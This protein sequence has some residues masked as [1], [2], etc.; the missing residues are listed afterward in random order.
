MTDNFDENLQK[1]I[2]SVTI[3]AKSNG[4]GVSQKTIYQTKF[5]TII[6]YAFHIPDQNTGETHHFVLEFKIWKRKNTREEWA[7]E[8]TEQN[9][10]S[11]D[12]YSLKIDKPEAVENLIKFL[13]LEF[14][15]IGKKMCGT[16]TI[17]DNPNEIDFSF[18]STLSNE[19]ISDLSNLVNIK[20][21]KN[22][23]DEW[24]ENKQNSNESYWQNLLK[25]N[26]LILSQIFACPFIFIKDQFFCGGKTGSN[27]GGI[28]TDFIYQNNLTQNTAFIEIKTPQ[29][30]LVNKSL[31]LGKNDD[32]NNAI[33]SISS[34]LTGGVNEVLNQKNIFI[35][36]KDSIEE[37]E[38]QHLNFKCVFLGGMIS[39]LTKGQIKSFELYRSSLRDVE[40]I[41]Y[42]ELF[43]RIELILNIFEK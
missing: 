4:F 38:K 35:Q 11:G 17:V 42:D 30:I 34:D 39:S 27:S 3:K 20:K 18:V 13:N 12:K 36:K 23:L 10:F 1:E 16:R 19:K 28:E 24:K 5:T 22:I 29:A 21:I 37:I 6:V 2:D 15:Q 43:E 9:F 25:E 40:I 41:T 31:Y 7:P 8:I 26:N 14:E 32:D 33:Y